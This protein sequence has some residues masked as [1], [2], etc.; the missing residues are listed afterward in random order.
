MAK[1]RRNVRAGGV[2]VQVL[3]DVVP[4]R[5]GVDLLAGVLVA[6][7]EM[8]ENDETVALELEAALVPRGDPVIDAAAAARRVG[9]GAVA[10]GECG[11]LLHGVGPGQ[12]RQPVDEGLV[13]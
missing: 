4:R 5:P 7:G 13:G 8:G 11:L 6:G 1:S 3:F 2:G 10:Q 9:G 12:P